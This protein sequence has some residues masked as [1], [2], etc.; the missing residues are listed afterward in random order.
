VLGR[1]VDT[2]ELEASYN[3]WRVEAVDVSQRRSNKKKSLSTNCH[4]CLNDGS[5]GFQGPNPINLTDITEISR[6][7]LLL[8]SLRWSSFDTGSSNLW[9]PSSACTSI[10]CFTHDTFKNSKSST[11]KKDGRPLDIQYASG[12]V[13]GA[14]GIDT[15]TWAGAAVT[16]VTFGEMTTLSGISFVAAKFDGIL[17]MGWHTVSA[18]NIPPVY[19]SMFA[20]GLIEDNSF[21]FY[22]SKVPG[23]EASKLVLGG[24]DNTLAKGAFN[25]VT[26]QADTYWQFYIQSISI[27]TTEVSGAGFEG[28]VFT[29]TSLLLGDKNS[30]KS[31]PW[32]AP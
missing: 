24:V 21:S 20:Q 25:Y 23:S 17:G 11:Y 5:R 9:V 27:G 12:G 4:E 16:S 30:T 31:M 29:E 18:Y 10:A 22:L 6:S 13:K 1:R 32:S 28:V 8:R 26:L 7:A 15:V 3:K 14:L 19:E 2:R